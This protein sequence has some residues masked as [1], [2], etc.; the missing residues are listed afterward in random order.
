[1]AIIA[2]YNLTS[3]LKDSISG[4]SLDANGFTEDYLVYSNY[5][6]SGFTTS[7]YLSLIHI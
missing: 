6:V 1:M 5:G 3:D 2:Q 7:L 4:N